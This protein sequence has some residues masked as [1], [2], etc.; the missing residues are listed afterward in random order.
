M[1][2]V[3][4]FSIAGK[5]KNTTIT[6]I[7]EDLVS[8]PYISE[9]DKKLVRHTL[10]V[11]ANGNYPDATYY[12]T[13]FNKSVLTYSSIAEIITYT[14]KLKDFYKRQTLTKGLISI[15]NDA[16]SSKALL[17]SL[18]ELIGTV[19]STPDEDGTYDSFIP[20]LYSDLI[21]KPFTDGYLSGIPEIDQLTNGFQPG[22]VGS[23]A[24]F[25]AE[26]KSTFICSFIFKNALA[27]KKCVL[28]S[29][30][31]APEILWMQF[32]A[33]YL[34]EVKGIQITAQ[35][36]IFKKLTEENERMIAKYDDDFRRDIV[37]NLMIVDESILSKAIIGDYKK[38]TKLYQGIEKVLGCIDI[39]AW[40]HVG[41]LELLYPEMGNIAVR[42]ITSFTKTYYNTKGIHPY[43]MLAVQ[44]NREGKKRA[45]KRNGVYDLQA[46][47]D[48]NE[49]ERSS[50]YCIF[51]FTSD[52]SKIVQE[53]K[54]SMQKHRLGSVLSEPAVVTFNPAVITIGTSVEKI[55]SDESDFSQIFGGSFDDSF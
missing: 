19:E 17:D 4:F 25:V 41:Q 27:G 22:T 5:K 35:D 2:D 52:D 45:A 47:S 38:L 43:T 40:D 44:T 26:G 6:S 20:A 23:V 13:F 36:L 11:V 51:L 7:L 39:A 16:S 55:S 42:N 37:Q 29:I 24:A 48:L 46:I 12:S 18:N 3:L 21:K 28:H 15:I 30:E 50:T 54:I 34:F 32:Q 8:Q 33:R 1:I 14:N 49:V 9:S 10:E 31:M 53:T